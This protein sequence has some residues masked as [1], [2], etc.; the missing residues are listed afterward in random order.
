M[1]VQMQFRPNPVDKHVGMRVAR[2][3]QSLGV[4]QR[5]MAVRLGLPLPMLKKYEAGLTRICASELYSICRM[6]GVQL[7]FFFEDMQFET[8]A[9]T[10][11]AETESSLQARA[12]ATAA[13]RGHC[14]AGHAASTAPRV[15]PDAMVIGVGAGKRVSAV[16]RG[17]GLDKLVAAQA[18]DSQDRRR[19]ERRK[20]RIE[21]VVRH[22][23]HSL[24]AIVENISL[25]GIKLADRFGLS[26]GEIVEIELAGDWVAGKVV[27]AASGKVGLQFERPLPRLPI[28]A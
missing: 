3:R 11:V 19:A 5:Q 20:F 1:G 25:T 13:S 18:N 16:L 15:A 8:P 17:G 28:A 22:K 26:S 12:L 9:L 14:L 21:V 4:S 6:L 27:W 24:P 7:S 2:A 23:G 10:L